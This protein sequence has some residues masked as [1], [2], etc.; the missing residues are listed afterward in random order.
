MATTFRSLG[1]IKDRDLRLT[2]KSQT[3]SGRDTIFS[4][5]AA[6]RNRANFEV[7]TVKPGQFSMA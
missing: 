6:I 2:K 1:L 4:S 3:Q 7:S 5:T